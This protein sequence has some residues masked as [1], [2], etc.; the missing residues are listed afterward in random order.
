MKITVDTNVLISATFWYG[1][2]FRILERVEN[3]EIELILSHEIIKE[4][5]EV[6]AYNEIQEKIQAKQLTMKQTVQKI[7][8]MATLAYPSEKINIVKDDPDDNAVL[9]CA[10]EGDVNYIITN[11]KH[12]LKLKEFQEIKI[13][14][15]AEFLAIPHQ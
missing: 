12:L 15:P 4:Y 11:D 10:L 6:L 5:E 14:T 13:I 7:Q 8:S 3:K 2:S 1:D 9:E